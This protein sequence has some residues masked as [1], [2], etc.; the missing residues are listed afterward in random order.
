MFKRIKQN[1]ILFIAKI[2][3]KPLL[4]LYRHTL[5]IKVCHRHYLWQARE[6]EKNVIF[7]F[8]HE[9]MLLALLVHAGQKIHVLVS[10]HFDGEIIAS[11]LY[12]F[13]MRTVR[14]SSTRGGS[15]AYQK[16]KERL[17]KPGFE[18]AFT[19]DGPTGPR[20]QVK[21][22]VVRLA[23]ETGKP[24]IPFAVAAKKY[25]RLNS[26]D[27]MLIILPFS[28]CA[29]VYGKPF[30]VPPALNG[31]QLQEYANRLTQITNQLEKEAELCIS[32]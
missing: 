11:I 2:L 1:I 28:R 29:L 27:R 6:Q 30:F 17:E 10:Q 23:S 21:F 18:I 24:I 31:P 3:A 14:G 22:G 9:N 19:P 15:V 13:G 12:N 5:H 32:R 16:M 4:L 7:S 20:R 25:R 26:W 8:W